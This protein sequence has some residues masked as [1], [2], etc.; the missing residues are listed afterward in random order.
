[1]RH[2]RKTRF[3]RKHILKL[4][5]GLALF[6]PYPP[7][8]QSVPAEST[9]PLSNFTSHTQRIGRTWLGGMAGKPKKA[10]N[11]TNVE[12]FSSLKGYVAGVASEYTQ[13]ISGA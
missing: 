6:S 8:Y 11:C 4:V 9:Y 12:A 2:A 7:T 10:A 13:A 5:P 1:M 3:S